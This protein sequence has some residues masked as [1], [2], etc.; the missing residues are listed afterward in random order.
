ME[1]RLLLARQKGRMFVDIRTD[2][3]EQMEKN[4]PVLLKNLWGGGTTDHLHDV[5]HNSK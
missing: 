1:T 2:F 5:H 4:V 3:Y